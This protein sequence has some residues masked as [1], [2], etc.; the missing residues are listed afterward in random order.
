M[1]RVV[2]RRTL[3]LLACVA[4]TLAAQT[5]VSRTEERAVLAE[6]VNINSS[7]GTLGV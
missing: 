7:S 6:L 1:I 4:T 5:P 3:T 2:A